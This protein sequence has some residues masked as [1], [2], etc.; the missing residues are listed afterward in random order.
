MLRII[1]VHA[2]I[3]WDLFFILFLQLDFKMVL[4]ILFIRYGVAF[5]FFFGGHDRV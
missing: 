1:P 3:T 4:E 2:C 5:F